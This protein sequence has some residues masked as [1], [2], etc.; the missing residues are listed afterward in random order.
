MIL[1]SRG[2]VAPDWI[3]EQD[4]THWA[5]HAL[6]LREAPAEVNLRLCDA[7]EMRRT[8]QQYAGKDYATNVLAFPADAPPDLPTDADPPPLLGDILICAPVVDE[9]AQSQGKTRRQHCAH[10]VTHGVLHLLGYDHQEDQE[11]EEMERAEVRLLAALGF[12]DPYLPSVS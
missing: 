12:P 3:S 8:N 2:N 4:L 7:T 6:T 1:I 9:E 5:T 11:A 10:L